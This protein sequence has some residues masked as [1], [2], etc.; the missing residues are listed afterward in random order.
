MRKVKLEGALRS[1]KKCYSNS[2]RFA[3]DCSTMKQWIF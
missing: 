1:V 2:K 3:A